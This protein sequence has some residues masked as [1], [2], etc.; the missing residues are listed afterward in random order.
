MFP[1]NAVTVAPSMDTEA[2]AIQFSPR[3]FLVPNLVYRTANGLDCWAVSDAAPGAL[4][5]FAKI[6]QEEH[7]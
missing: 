4:H 2:E 1:R 7:S 3:F 6:Q 5:E